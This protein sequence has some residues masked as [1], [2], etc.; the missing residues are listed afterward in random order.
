MLIPGLWSCPLSSSF[1]PISLHLPR[2][3]P[4]ATEDHLFKSR[5][6]PHGLHCVHTLVNTRRKRLLRLK[7]VL[8]ILIS[9]SAVCSLACDSTLLFAGLMEVHWLIELMA[10]QSFL[11]CRAFPVLAQRLIHPPC[12]LVQQMPSRSRRKG[13][14]MTR[15]SSGYE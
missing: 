15:E 7:T 6:C 4:L 3:H 12:G 10:L 1:S 13:Q 11:H 8:L 5:L 14:R 2:V 9:S